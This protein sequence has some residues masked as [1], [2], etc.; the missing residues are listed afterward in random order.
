MLASYL[1]L[2][3]L[4]GYGVQGVFVVVAAILGVGALSTAL[5]GTETKRLSLEAIS[6][7]DLTVPAAAR[8]LTAP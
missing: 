6:T 1:M 7:A 5:L 3:I 8:V 4:A 2:G